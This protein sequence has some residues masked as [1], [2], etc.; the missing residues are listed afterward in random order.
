MLLDAPVALHTPGKKPG[1]DKRDAFPIEARNID[2]EEMSLKKKLLLS[3]INLIIDP[4]SVSTTR[5]LVSSS[6]KLEVVH[7]ELE[8]T[9]TTNKKGE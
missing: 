6:V 9:I 2:F 5:R 4:E 7:F 1:N 8:L 3:S